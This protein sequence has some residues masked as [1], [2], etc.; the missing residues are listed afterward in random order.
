M[1]TLYKRKQILLPKICCYMKLLQFIFIL[2]YL[3]LVNSSIAQPN[4]LKSTIYPKTVGY[5]SLIL[6]I[7][8]LNKEK[9]TNDFSNFKDGFAIGFPVGVNIL[10]SERFGFS[11]EITPTIQTKAGSTKTSKILFDPGTMF[12]FQHGFTII[13]RLAF[14]TS[15]RYGFTPVFN[16]IVSRTKAANYFLAASLPCRFGNSDLPSIGGSLQFGFI[17]N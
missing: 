13:T 16:K 7:V 6:P 1:V 10:Y 8:T 11:Y 17:F 9:I 14:E 4:K 15:G 2:G 3:F 12:R 5:F